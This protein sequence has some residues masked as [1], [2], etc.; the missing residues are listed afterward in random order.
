MPRFN[1]Y[2]YE[3]L[4]N[5]PRNFEEKLSINKVENNKLNSFKNEK[6]V[7]ESKLKKAAKKIWK[8][9]GEWSQWKELGGM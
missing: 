3:R 4:G 2:L 6:V 8:E 5:W 9:L 1:K 7:E